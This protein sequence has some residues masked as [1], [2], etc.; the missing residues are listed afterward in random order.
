MKINALTFAESEWAELEIWKIVE[1]ILMMILY[2]LGLL[3]L[4]AKVETNLAS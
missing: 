4:L 2:I 3:L 1:G